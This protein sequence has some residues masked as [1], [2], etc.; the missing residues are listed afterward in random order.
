MHDV[1]A[2]AKTQPPPGE[3]DT[4]HMIWLAKVDIP[5]LPHVGYLGVLDLELY[6]DLDAPFVTE[7]WGARCAG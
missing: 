3:P 7:D 1:I 5:G 4:V 6:T 2:R